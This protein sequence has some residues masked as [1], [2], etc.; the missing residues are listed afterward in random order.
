MFLEEGS[1]MQ[2]T[3]RCK[4]IDNLIQLTVDL[5]KVKYNSGSLKIKDLWALTLR[6]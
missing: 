6:A 3:E 2:K 5:F 1:P 4:K